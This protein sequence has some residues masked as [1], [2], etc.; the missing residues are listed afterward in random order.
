MEELDY[1]PYKQPLAPYEEGFGY[2][3]AVGLTKDGEKIQ[4]HICGKLFRSL[5]IHIRKAHALTLPMY[6]KQFKLMYKSSLTAPKVREKY[7]A[8]WHKLPEKYRATRLKNLAAARPYLSKGG[9]NKSLEQRNMEGS[10]P[11]QLIEKIKALAVVLGRTPSSREFYRYYKGYI[12]TVYRTFGSWSNALK[13]ADMMPAR[14]G[15]KPSYNRK[16]LE[17]MLADFVKYHKRPPTSGDCVNG[18]LP[19]AYT[20][21]KY[22]GS[23]SNAVKFAEGVRDGR[24]NGGR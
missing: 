23:W 7:I 16:V 14:V 24:H 4:C 8:S 19:S 10:C 22:F 9:W 18:L 20:F 17:A 6:R 13:I 12:Q 11:D 21:K 1:N 2:Y 3:G 15:V 5:G